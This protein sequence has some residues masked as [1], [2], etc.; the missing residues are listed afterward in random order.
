MM[1]KYRLDLI[2]PFGLF[3]P[4][5]RRIDIT[6]KKSVALI[7][8][9]IVSPSGVRSRRWL[10]NMLW[11]TREDIQAQTSLRRELSN[12]TKQLAVMDADHLLVRGT[13]RIGL[14]IEQ[15]EVDIFSLGLQMAKHKSS[16][17]SDFLEG[18]DLRDCE[19]F[20]DWLRAERDRVR[21]MIAID[22][23]E[24]ADVLPSGPEILG[25]DLPSS[26]EI[27][28]NRSPRLPPKPS[29]AVLPFASLPDDDGWLGAGIAD[30]LGVILSQYPQLFIVASSSARA[31]AAQQLPRP[32]IADR[33]GVRYLLDGTVMRAGDRLRL[34]VVL[35]NGETG[36]QVWAQAF[37]GCT[38]DVF[39]LQ[40]EIADR[41]A[42]QIWSKVDI[43]ERQRGLRMIGSP[44]GG[45][46]LY[47]RANALFRSGDKEHLFEATALAEQLVEQDPTCPWAASLASYC[48]SI[49]YLRRLV[50]DYEASLR[51]AI[52][53]Y[54]SAMRF[55][56]DNVEALGYAAGT[57]VNIGGDMG[58]ADRIIS[59]A[60]HL[61]PAHQPTLFW[62]GWVDIASGRP[63]RA[64]D[65]LELALRINPATGARAQTLCGIGLA[66]LQQGKAQEA[67][68]FLQ[69][70]AQD[71]NGAF[72]R[73][74]GLYV[75][76]SLIGETE[77]A[78]EAALALGDGDYAGVIKMFNDP[79]HQALFEQALHSRAIGP[80]S[81]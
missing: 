44:A 76:A 75:A 8:L 35:I 59:H 3:T 42:P 25:M 10:Q 67:F 6:S 46:E 27:L 60:L 22:L 63:D 29:L 24:S 45:Y 7:A 57:L 53:H 5:G 39:V 9:I 79:Q 43:A 58:V 81:A 30:E 52:I 13:Q 32:E 20:E 77:I 66:C 78:R 55:G 17:S 18:I 65:R 69:Q 70:A 62:G 48:H 2:G 38:D 51:R 1:E 40:R 37:E 19:E 36:E 54:Q 72:I 34:S 31:L 80:M 68:L 28:S 15:L 4:D 74:L 73:H 64:R 49:I 12:L 71:G 41:I 61:L 33:L 47:W 56:S 11:G 26:E 23:P 21:D 16:L 50:P 14:A